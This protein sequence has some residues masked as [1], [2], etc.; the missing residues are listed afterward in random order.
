MKNAGSIDEN[1]KFLVDS[2]LDCA[3][4]VGRSG[5]PIKI[6]AVSKFQPVEKIIQAI[7][8]GATDFGENYAEQAVDKIHMLEEKQIRWHMIGHI[9]SRK[10]E[11]VVENFDYIHTIDSI[12]IARRLSDKAITL[13]KIIDCLVELN[14]ADEETKSGYRVIDEFHFEQFSEELTLMKELSGIRLNGLMSMPPVGIPHEETSKFFNQTREIL[15]KSS[16][17]VQASSWKELSMGT[18][19]DYKL[20]IE[21]GSTIVRIGTSIFGERLER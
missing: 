1:Y 5:D 7:E 9:Q 15:E 18:S 8:A 21:C 20:A 11:I 6:V 16:K 13:G 12:K 10:A 2:I 19:S 4:K 14:I 17:I 3:N